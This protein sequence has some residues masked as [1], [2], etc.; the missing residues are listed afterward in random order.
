M[1]IEIHDAALEAR[2]QKQL[3]A[4]GSGSV[5][6]VLLRLLE[7]QEE[8]DRWL[9]ENRETIRAKI[10]RGIAQLDRGEGIPEDQLDAYLAELKAKP[11]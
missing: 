11:E 5:E 7:T 2:I 1:N 10:Q 4:T 3:Q 9:L 6:E 8:Q